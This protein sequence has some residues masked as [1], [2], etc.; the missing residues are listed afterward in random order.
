MR[1]LDKTQALQRLADETAAVSPQG[2]CMACGLVGSAAGEDAHI[3]GTEHGVVVLNRYAQREGHLMV[4]ARAHIEQTHE[5]PYAVYAELQR[6]VYVAT[7]VLQHRFRP[8]RIYTAALGSPVPLQNSYPH[9]HFHVVP[10]METDERARPARVFSWSEGVVMYD[11]DEA[12]ALVDGLR[13][14]WASAERAANGFG[15]C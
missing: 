2:Q 7:R 5:M 8:A 4:I 9:V 14:D 6:A 13:E 11:D 12:A 1:V 3:A 10:V 15:N